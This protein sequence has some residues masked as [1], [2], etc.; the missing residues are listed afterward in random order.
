M[1]SLNHPPGNMTGK[2]IM[3]KLTRRLKKKIPSEFQSD[4]FDRGLTRFGA[5]VL[6]N[7]V[8]RIK[9]CREEARRVR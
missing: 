4:I 9:K 6:V 5:Y 3:K 2:S 8:C 7:T 1:L